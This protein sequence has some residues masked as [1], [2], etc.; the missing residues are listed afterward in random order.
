MSSDDIPKGR[1]WSLELN[2]S[3]K[4]HRIGLL[5]VTPENMTAPWLV[6]EAGALS[7]S[8]GEASVV[9]LLL[10]MSPSALVGPLQQFQAA[11]L[12]QNDLLKALLDLNASSQMRVPEE[13]LKDSFERLW[14]ELQQTLQDIELRSLPGSHRTIDSVVRALSKHR[15]AKPVS[16]GQIYFDSGF[17]SHSLYSTLTEIVSRRLL[18]FGRKN[19]KLFDKDHQDFLRSLRRQVGVGFDFRMLFLDPESSADILFAAHRDDD[20]PEQL[21]S[22]ISSACKIMSK[23][24][25]DPGVHFR[26]Y[27]THRTVSF[28]VVDDAVLFTAISIDE[29]GRVKPLTRVPFTL[30]E[31]STSCATELIESFEATW[32]ISRKPP[33]AS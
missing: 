3:L 13:I 14:P 21:R 23:F 29:Y 1:H 17:E 4:D 20:F 15:I 5:C 8:L 18:I 10:G 28:I 26:L 16:S 12:D 27:R 31:A 2:R 22:C 30:V 6:F 7:R 19:R 11:T 32:R 24:E 9:P 33:A 25:L